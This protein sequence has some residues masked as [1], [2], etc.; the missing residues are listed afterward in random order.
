[1]EEAELIAA[2]VGITE[3]VKNLGIPAKYCTT[4]AILL[5]VVLA[6][7][8]EHTWGHGNYMIAA[9]RGVIFGTTATGLYSVGDKVIEKSKNGNSRLET[10]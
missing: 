3:V 5:G 7:V 1:M 9:I 8:A 4:I 10:N 6:I 2:V